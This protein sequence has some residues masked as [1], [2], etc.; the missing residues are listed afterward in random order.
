MTKRVL[1][2]AVVVLL[3]VAFV[4]T[5]AFADKYRPEKK[6]DARIQ[7]AADFSFR[8]PLPVENNNV[9]GTPDRTST[10]SS[11]GDPNISDS[12]GSVMGFTYYELQK[13]GAIGR[14]VEN[15]GGAQI[16]VTLT[17]A[18]DAAYA[19]R[20]QVYNFY[21]PVSGS[22]IGN[23]FQTGPGSTRSGFG[24]IDVIP[25]SSGVFDTR[26][27]VTGHYTRSD[28]RAEANFQDPDTGPGVF[29]FKTIAESDE[30]AGAVTGTNPLWPIIEYHNN[31]ANDYVY[32]VAMGD[33]IGAPLNQDTDN[34]YF[35]RKAGTD[36]A[37]AWEGTI[38]DTVAAQSYSIASS[39]TTQKVAVAYYQYQGASAWDAG[40][41]A[42]VVYK[43]ST[44][45][46]ATWPATY[47]NVTN[48]PAPASQTDTVL[49]FP[50]GQETSCLYDSNDN[51]HIVWKSGVFTDSSMFFSAQAW[52]WAEHIGTL[53]QITR[54]W[55]NDDG[56]DCGNGSNNSATGNKI[57]IAECDGNLYTVW[58]QAN[59]VDAGLY[60]DCANGVAAGGGVSINWTGNH[61]LYMSVSTDLDGTAWDARRNLTNSYNPACSLSTSTR[62]EC[63]DDIM[64]T[65]SRYG[66]DISLLGLTEGDYP[67]IAIVDVDPSYTGTSYLDITYVN[68]EMP[69]ISVY[70]WSTTSG[71]QGPA[72]RNNAKWFRIP[73]V[74]P[75]VEAQLDLNINSIGYPSYTRHGIPYS[76][77]LKIENLGNLGLSVTGI[78]ENETSGPSGWLDVF[79]TTLSV[80]PTGGKDSVQVTLNAGGVVNSPGTVVSLNGSLDFL[81]NA[82][83]GTVT[84]TI[85]NFIVADTIVGV[86]YDTIS[87]GCIR[88]AV[89]RNGNMG[90]QGGEEGTANMDFY[91][92]G[93]E[94]DTVPTGVTD[95]LLGDASVY[96]YDG[97]PIIMSG[98]LGNLTA[99]WSIFQDGFETEYGFKPVSGMTDQGPVT[100][101]NYDGWTSGT[102]V[103]TDSA[104][105]VEKTWYAPTA[106]GD[107]CN[108]I[109]QG[110]KIY[111]Y[112]GAAHNDLVIGEA[113]DWDVPSD[114]GS[115]NA[116]GFDPTQNY[117]YLRGAEYDADPVECQQNS[118]RWGGAGFVG[119]FT[120]L[121]GTFMDGN[122]GLN[123]YGMYTALNEDFV[124]PRPARLEGGFDPD[125]LYT[126]MTDNS[127]LVASPTQ[128]DQH[129]V[130]TLS[131][132]FDL[133]ANDTLWVY[134]VLASV[135]NGSQTDL[136][137]AIAA[138]R[139]WYQENLVTGGCCVGLTGNTNNDPGDATDLSDLIYLVNYLF[140]GGPA[141][142]C[143]AEANVNGD[144][145]CSVDLSDLIYLVN[146]LFLG[147]PAPAACNPACE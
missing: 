45:M 74:D 86:T 121:D 128:T 36:T 107:S 63:N 114:T 39:R 65:L 69:S 31:G 91:L 41:R 6:R 85:D 42:D 19:S 146:Y 46:G 35:F 143:G 60:D 16:H 81:S 141:P 98:T 117:I 115:N 29:D 56:P 83:V 61:E 111:S 100:G 5:P 96:M 103:T 94:C 24:G 33:G 38:L 2:V 131:T 134:V 47:T 3:V 109:I 28:T 58:S 20:Y 145:G 137:D 84:F 113:M 136:G 105:A 21:D 118:A 99:S 68:D 48:H 124:Y 80:P 126:N 54:H 17:S 104:I 59:D 75:V 78:T 147:G 12:P 13:N 27:V 15:R 139:Q 49:T 30:P 138:G 120:Q 132:D 77:Y 43:E 97:S 70:E 52:H 67:A 1:A 133:A 50:V 79:P 127:G 32:I 51:L 71:F 125:E 37:G 95:T 57:S 7:T 92:S 108:F 44:D 129:M 76:F 25:Y 116:G 140:L 90:N 64:G 88:L 62:G 34:L 14:R 18:L 93:D 40:W 106:G 101:A 72:T 55:W 102:F 135:R 22:A 87:T 123:Y 142:V 82:A 130:L 4:T 122:D 73:C 10:Q 11:L 144:I 119:W 53:N 9:A 26:A 110:M 112:D 66:Q 8:N 23:Q 89:G